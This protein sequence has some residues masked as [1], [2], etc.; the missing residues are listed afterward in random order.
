[1]SSRETSTIAFV[2][3]L[4]GGILILLGV[5]MMWM[6]LMFEGFNFGSMMNGFGHMMEGY[7]D[8]MHSLGFA[9]GFM[10]G[11]PLIGLTS[12]IAVIIGAVMLNVQPTA[13]MT[14]GTIILA[15]SVVSFLSMGGFWIG[16]ILG[17]AGGALAIST[18][19]VQRGKI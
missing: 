19:P 10:M 15:F 14:W 11:L 16:A 5:G 17:I 8:M 9:R 3:S 12:G 18:R 6:W 4:I 1:L 7:G 2:L 13:H